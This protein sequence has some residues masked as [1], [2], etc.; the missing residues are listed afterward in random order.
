[1]TAVPP[2][3]PEPSSRA[4]APPTG[5]YND[6]LSPPPFQ[7]PQPPPQRPRSSLPWILGGVGA[8]VLLICC[9]GVVVA[10][11][12][13]SRG[14]G[15]LAGNISAA[16]NRADDYYSAIQSHDWSRAYGYLDSKTQSTT[17]AAVIQRTWTARETANGRITG[18]FRDQ[19]Q[20]EHPQRQ[21]H[22]HRHRHPALQLRHH[23]NHD[24]LPGQ[25]RQRLEVLR[26][27]ISTELPVVVKSGGTKAQS[28]G[29]AIS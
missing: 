28:C 7:P 22:R 25:R 2:P 3:G 10:G 13:L 23:R 4:F 27:A 9:V 11:V 17:T 6:Q 5:L 15:S 21:D 20:R 26:A 1:M 29:T 19:H 16:Q 18:Y 14:V 24:R 12:L 8:A